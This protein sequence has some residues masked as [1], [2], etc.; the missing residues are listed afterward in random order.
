[1]YKHYRSILAEGIGDGSLRRFSPEYLGAGICRWAEELGCTLKNGTGAKAMTRLTDNSIRPGPSSNVTVA[2]S[3][4]VYGMAL[5]GGML[6]I[7]LYH[8]RDKPSWGQLLLSPSVILCMV[9]VLGLLVASGVLVRFLCVSK[10]RN[11]DRVNAV[12]MSLLV[13]VLVGGI[14]EVALRIAAVERH[15][16]TFVGK[17]RLLPRQW[18]EFADRNLAMLARASQLK[19]FAVSDDTLGWTVVPNRKSEDGL[20]EI[21]AEGLRSATQG[22]VLRN[23]LGDCR[24]ALVGDSFTFGDDVRFED[25]W[26]YRLEQ[27]LPKGCRVLNFGVGGYGIDQMYLRYRRDVPS[28]KPNLVILSFIDPDLDRT[29]S[30]YAFLFFEQGNSLPKPRFVLDQRGTLNIVN[31]PLP[32]AEDVFMRPSIHDVPFVEYDQ[33][34]NRADWDRPQWWYVHRSYFLRLLISLYR[35]SEKDRPFVSDADMRAL[36][37]RLLHAFVDAVHKDGATPLLV[38]LPNGRDFKKKSPWISDG[39]QILQHAHLQHVDLTSCLKRDPEPNH[40]IRMGG[41]HGGHYTLQANAT[42]AA[43]LGPIVRDRLG[44]AKA[45]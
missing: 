36:N 8:Y 5:C 38:Y 31:Q 11:R 19:T 33:K 44:L 25:S 2:I 17:F 32:K 34:Y 21:S 26:A 23:G 12:V 28:W 22:E 35:F 9:A 4:A 43:C 14:G 16:G 42:V 30:A 1:V 13:I 20:Y 15:H 45:E 40:F 37:S 24:V 6:L 41:G 10:G 3:M 7:G 29:M 27:L 39:L 18:R